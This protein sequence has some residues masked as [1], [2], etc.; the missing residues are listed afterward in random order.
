VGQVTSGTFAP[1][2]Q[3]S[4]AIAYVEPASAEPG[5]TIEVEVRGQRYAATTV[6][7]PFYRRPRRRSR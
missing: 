6:A 1:T 5:R 4:I 3:K 2:L 7:L